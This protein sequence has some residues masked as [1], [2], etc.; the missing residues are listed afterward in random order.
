MHWDDPAAVELRCRF[1]GGYLPV[2][3][4]TAATAAAAAAAAELD[5]GGGGEEEVIISGVREL[6]GL[7]LLVMSLLGI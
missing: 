2:W 1:A 6:E 7:A 3:T 4:S 5:G